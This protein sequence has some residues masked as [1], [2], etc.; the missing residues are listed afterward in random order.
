M[1]HEQLTL[2]GLI[3]R[4]AKL[5]AECSIQWDF[6]YLKP[7]AVGSYRGYYEQLAIGHTDGHEDGF[8]TVGELLAN[9]RAA[10]G[11][12]F[13]GYKGGSYVMHR[14]TPVWLGN[15]GESGAHMVV[16][17]KA[18]RAHDSTYFGAYLVTARDDEDDLEVVSP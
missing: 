18:Y 11:A 17:V 7:T 15:Y 9:L 5:P 8:R 16:A 2:G 4:L 1:T 13:T 10:V 14:D 6:G 3:D 12:T